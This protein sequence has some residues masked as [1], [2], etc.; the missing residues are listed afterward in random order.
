[1]LYLGR[2]LSNTNNYNAR[3]SI[4]VVDDDPDTPTLIEQSLNRNGFKVS[5]F[6]NPLRALE[7]FRVNCKTCS[8]V[9]SDI[10]M[11]GTNGYELVKKVKERLINK[12]R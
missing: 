7:D 12:P 2:D 8:L 4:L 5:T 9:L 10:R 3:T 1:M 11:P 6:T